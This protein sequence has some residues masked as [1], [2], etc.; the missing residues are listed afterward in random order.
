MPGISLQRA[1]QLFD[2]VNSRL[3][4]AAISSSPCIPFAYP[5][6]GCWGRAHEMCRLMIADGAQPN[7]IWIR[8]TLRVSS[9]NKPD[10]LVR[11][12]WHVA[13]TVEVSTSVGDRTYVID[14]A[15][16]NEPV[17]QDTWKGIQGDPGAVLTPTGPEIF[18]Y[19]YPPDTYDPT[20]AKS[21]GVL[22]TYRM[23]LRLRSAEPHGPPPYDNCMVRPAGTQWFGLIG[24]NATRRWFTWG[25]PADRHVI[26]SVMPLTP[27]VGGPQLT[28][29]VAVERASNTQCTYWITVQNVS[30]AAVKFEGRYDILN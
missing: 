15:L 10:C 20:Y 28:W 5:D 6:D 25:W 16:F 1:R 9:A 3:C 21:N 19:Y 23:Q 17:P 12:G 22:D 4:C 26:W 29:S 11:W 30:S 8:G 7:K 13:P 14:P 2:L 18:H 27:C 24:A